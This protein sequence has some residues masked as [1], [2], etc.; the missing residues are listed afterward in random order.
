MPKRMLENPGFMVIVA[1]WQQKR[2]VSWCVCV[3]VSFM[4]VTPP[5]LMAPHCVQ[6]PALSCSLLSHSHTQINACTQR[7]RFWGVP[8]PNTLHNTPPLHLLLP[9]SRMKAGQWSSSTFLLSA[10]FRF[11]SSSLSRHFSPVYFVRW[12]ATFSHITCYTF[13]FCGVLNFSFWSTL[14]VPSAQKW[15]WRPGPP[16]A[17][18]ELLEASASNRWASCTNQT[19]N[20]AVTCVAHVR[21]ASQVVHHNKSTTCICSDWE[22][23]LAVNTWY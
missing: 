18:R 9:L 19:R 16:R 22:M 21:L 14:F 20:T 5:C 3:W 7:G 23:H 11:P 1:H 15:Q 10:L 13:T 12:V 6:R 8:H 2:K 4:W 17:F